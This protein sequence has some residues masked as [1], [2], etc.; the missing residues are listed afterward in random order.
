[1]VTDPSTQKGQHTTGSLSPPPQPLGSTRASL[2][3]EGVGGRA[4]ANAF[5]SEEGLGEA[6]LRRQAGLGLDHGLCGI[7][8]GGLTYSGP[9]FRTEELCPQL[10]HLRQGAGGGLD[11]PSLVCTS[12]IPSH[13]QVSRPPGA[14]KTREG[15]SLPSPQSPGMPKHPKIQ[16]KF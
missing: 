13:R 8:R 14:G 1:M 5:M 4:W 7:G 3:A 2:E 16:K 9:A 11:L 10:Q 12:N 6:T 15:Q